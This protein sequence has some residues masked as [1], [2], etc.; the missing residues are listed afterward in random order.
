[1]DAEL[2]FFVSNCYAEPAIRGGDERLQLIE[3]GCVVVF[4]WRH[5]MPDTGRGTETHSGSCGSAHIGCEV[6]PYAGISFRLFVHCQ[7]HMSI[8]DL[9]GRLSVCEFCLLLLTEQVSCSLKNGQQESWGR[10]KRS[11]NSITECQFLSTLETFQ[12]RRSATKFPA[13]RRRSRP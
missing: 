6:R 11:D 3:N 8:G 1:M 7:S 5:Q 9:Q 13:S 2:D 10:K 12:L 4:P